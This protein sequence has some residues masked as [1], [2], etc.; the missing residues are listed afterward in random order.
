MLIGRRIFHL[1]NY[2]KHSCF[3]SF[4]LYCEVFSKKKEI[5]HICVLT[6]HISKTVTIKNLL[7]NSFGKHGPLLFN[8]GCFMA[9]IIGIS[10]RS[11]SQ[12]QFCRFNET[13]KRFFGEDNSECPLHLKRFQGETLLFF[14]QILNRRFKTVSSWLILF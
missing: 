14:C 13:P 10:R 4:L 1:T 7:R 11:I 12:E 2:Y 5:I 3:R 8:F 6:I 9:L